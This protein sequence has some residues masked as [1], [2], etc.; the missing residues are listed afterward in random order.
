METEITRR[1]FKKKKFDGP[2][3]EPIDLVKLKRKQIGELTELAKSMGVE[4]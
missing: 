3:P 1:S 2:I 4:K